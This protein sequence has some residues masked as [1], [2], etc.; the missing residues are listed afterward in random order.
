MKGRDSVLLDNN[1]TVINIIKKDAVSSFHNTLN[2][3]LLDNNITVINIIKKDAVSSF[4]NTLNS[5][6]LDNNIMIHACGS[7][8]GTLK[9]HKIVTKLAYYIRIADYYYLTCVNNCC[10]NDRRLFET[11]DTE[12]MVLLSDVASSSF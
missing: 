12:T 11:V 10:K 4:H 6:L 8:H 2:S 1:E 3:V 7:F 5:V 9:Y